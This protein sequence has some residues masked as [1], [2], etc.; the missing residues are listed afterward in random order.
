MVRGQTKVYY[1]FPYGIYDVHY[2]SIANGVIVYESKVNWT[3]AAQEA[4]VALAV[5]A[6]V[7]EPGF[8]PIAVTAAIA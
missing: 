5:I 3:R 8:I 1:T 7:M 4:I 2:Y 6:A